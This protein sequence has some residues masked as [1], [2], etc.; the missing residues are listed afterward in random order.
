MF[1]RISGY[2][3]KWE[4]FKSPTSLGDCR[5]GARAV[6]HTRSAFLGARLGQRTA[7]GQPDAEGITQ[8]LAARADCSRQLR[9]SLPLPLAEISSPMQNYLTIGNVSDL[10]QLS[11]F[12]S[13][14]VHILL[15][16]SL[17][18]FS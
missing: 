16:F 18:F 14:Y 12:Q 7:R 9:Q 13:S 1:I 17:E 5:V 15:T 11:I 2:M 3:A 4:D 8:P 6:H 10:H